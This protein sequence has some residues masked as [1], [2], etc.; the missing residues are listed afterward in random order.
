VSVADLAADRDFAR[1]QRTLE[2][3]PAPEVLEFV[4]EFF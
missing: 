3:N 4:D 2:L 1:S